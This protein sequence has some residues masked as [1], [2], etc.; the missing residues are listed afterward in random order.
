MHNIYI[1][2]HRYVYV[3][4]DIRCICPRS[5]P[6]CLCLFVRCMC[7]RKHPYPGNTHSRTYIPAYLPTCT[8]PC[9]LC[10]SNP[11][12]MIEKRITT[13]FAFNFICLHAC[14]WTRVSSHIS[15]KIQ[16]EQM[17][18][19]CNSDDSEPA[20]LAMTPPQAEHVSLVQGPPR[21]FGQSCL[22]L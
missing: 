17:I 11:Y 20:V 12:I 6:V 9:K 18:K 5:N 3:Y 15:P 7:I 14:R 13:R 22:S 2:I 10:A 8:H 16:I 1:Y 19:R 4:R 21:R